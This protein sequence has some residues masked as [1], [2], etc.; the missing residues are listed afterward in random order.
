MSE[1]PH[2]N[3]GVKPTAQIVVTLLSDG[4]LTLQGPVHDKILCL[5]MLDLA[6]SM[7]TTAKAQPQ[8]PIVQVPRIPGL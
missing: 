1:V 5:G 7:V 6:K 2:V 8:S 3:G 4:Q